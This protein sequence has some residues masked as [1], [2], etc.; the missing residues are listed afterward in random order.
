MAEVPMLFPMEP[1][2]FWQQL[3][4]VIEEVVEQK[5]TAPIRQ[6]EN[7]AKKTLLKAKEVCE[8]FR[9][10]KPTLYEWMR[11]GRLTSVKISS[12]RYFLSQDV[13]Q[14]IQSSQVTISA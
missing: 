7:P 14:L 1:E 12:R 4:M 2:K 13:E 5:N 8:L 10:S 6:A 9:V 11:Q 3:R